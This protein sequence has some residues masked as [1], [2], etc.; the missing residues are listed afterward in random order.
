M[1]SFRCGAL[2]IRGLNTPV[3]HDAIRRYLTSNKLAI[4]AVMETHV[5]DKNFVV[6]NSFSSRWSLVTNKGLARN[7]RIAILWD[8][9]EVVL[10]VV[11]TNA[12]CIHCHVCAKTWEFQGFITF[13]YATN[14]AV[15]RGRLW[16]CVED[17]GR[18]IQE[19]WL[20][21]GDYNVIMSAEE[22]VTES[23]VV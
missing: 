18:R 1:V 19:P 10:Q 9:Q 20:I 6:F 7:V 4:L 21:A 14:S 5:R 16:N 23:G 3:K 17:F 2:N 22:K 15:E 12:Q 8:P 13:V 11:Y